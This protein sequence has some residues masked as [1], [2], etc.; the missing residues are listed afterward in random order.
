[1]PPRYD[2]RSFYLKKSSFSIEGRGG[3]S[4]PLD[5]ITHECVG[6]SLGRGHSR[7]KLTMNTANSQ[8]PYFTRRELAHF[9]RVSERLIR[10]RER[11]GVFPIQRLPAIGR[12]PRYSAEDVHRYCTGALSGSTTKPYRKP[13]V[14]RRVRAIAGGTVV[15]GAENNSRSWCRESRVLFRWA[16]GRNADGS[17]HARGGGSSA[18]A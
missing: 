8:Q 3:L 1:M 7:I 14:R 18:N 4:N 2:L 17:A 6:D 10:D 9:L 16:T 11:L 15:E 12:T 5:H 13:R